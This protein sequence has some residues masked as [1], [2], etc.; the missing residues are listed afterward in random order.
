MIYNGIHVVK[1]VWSEYDTVKG[2]ITLHW[3]PT[4]YSDLLDYVIYRDPGNSTTYSNS[5]Y[6]STLDTLFND[7]IFDTGS[8]FGKFSTSD[9]LSYSF[10]Y[11]IAIRNNSTSIGNAYGVIPVTAYPP[12]LVQTT[13]SFRIWEK[14]ISPYDTIHIST[15]VQNLAR[16]IQKLKW[17]T[18]SQKLF[19]D[20][21]ILPKTVK[22]VRDTLYTAF[23]TPGDHTIYIEATDGA[24]TIRILYTIV[25][26]H[27]YM[28]VAKAGNDMSV[29]ISDTVYL[30]GTATD[31]GTIVEYAWKIG[32][33]PWTNVSSADT[34]FIAP[35]KPTGSIL[36][37]LRVVDDDN[38]VSF[39]EVR[40]AVT[41]LAPIVYAGIDTTV[42]IGTEIHLHASVSDDGAINKY[43][44][45]FGNTEWVQTSSGDTTIIAPIDEG[46]YECAIRITD[47][48][49][50]SS[51]D[52]II[53][54]VERFTSHAVFTTVY[55]TNS[56]Y[57]ARHGW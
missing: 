32:T 56:V 10:K 27:E 42:G 52:V 45:S 13:C 35:V 53:I 12:S 49:G 30:H 46:P 39:D 4:K 37:S 6:A 36:C 34:F 26:V 38:Q 19:I 7:T 41:D 15:Y 24:G 29:S 8:Y 22:Y 20:S 55:G 3:S 1:N 54:Y 21:L 17:R 31:N 18:D 9:T 14:T 48:D 57:A 47:D 25:T 2:V 43:E 28:P 50:R 40:V 44:W 11:R 5:I 33:G 23:S 51:S 16:G